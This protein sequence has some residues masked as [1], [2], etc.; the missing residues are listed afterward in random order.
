ML[1]SFIQKHKAVVFYIL[2]LLT[3][4]LLLLLQSHIV[5]AN[6]Y[7]LSL[8]QLAPTISV[9]V[10]C[11]LAGESNVLMQIWKAVPLAKKH[12]NWVP[13]ILALTALAV[14]LTAGILSWCTIPYLKWSGTVCNAII[15]FCGCFFEE[16]GW[17]GFLLPL[18]ERRHNPLISTLIVGFLWG[19][20]HMSFHLGLVGFLLF[21]VTAIEMSFLMTWIY[22]ETSG[23]LLLMALWHASINIL[24]QI[25]LTGRLT[26]TGFGMFAIVLAVFCS[27]VFMKN[28]SLFLR[29]DL[30]SVSST[31]A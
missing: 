7:S 3:S 24:N 14:T 1:K 9:L 20:W 19:F 30:S 15:M 25:L 5:V 2:V 29:K 23:N 22:H 13:I 28:R 26:A 27:I 18:L 6:E 16:I 10:L 17:R 21:I 11:F 12:I 31:I 4:G 8:P